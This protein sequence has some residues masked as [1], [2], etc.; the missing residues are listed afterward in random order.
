MTTLPRILIIDDDLAS[1]AERQTMICEALALRNSRDKTKTN[2]RNYLA[3]A[4]FETGQTNLSDGSKVNDLDAVMK[5]IRK[6]WPSKVDGERWA[7][8]CIDLSFNVGTPGSDNEKATF[9]GA[10][11]VGK[12]RSTWPEST[13]IVSETGT[14]LPIA[15]LSSQDTKEVSASVVGSSVPCLEKRFG[16]AKAM[17]KQFAQALFSHGLVRD[18][19]LR[20]PTSPDV[21][22]PVDRRHALVTG[23][24]FSVLRALQRARQLLLTRPYQN[25]LVVGSLGSES[26]QFAHYLNDHLDVAHRLFRDASIPGK[27]EVK[28]CLAREGAPP[29]RLTNF[30][31]VFLE[32]L[33]DL[34]QTGYPALRELA[35]NGERSYLLAASIDPADAEERRLDQLP[36]NLR[37]AFK[38]LQWPPL[39]ERGCDASTFFAEQLKNALVQCNLPTPPIDPEAASYIDKNIADFAQIRDLAEEIVPQILYRPEVLERDVRAAFERI[40]GRTNATEET[41][42]IEALEVIRRTRF[43]NGDLPQSWRSLRDALSPLILQMFST[44]A[45]QH[46]VTKD[47][48]TDG[49]T[50]WAD[51]IGAPVYDTTK[52]K[53]IPR[54][55]AYLSKAFELDDLSELANAGD[56]A[57]ESKKTPKGG[58]DA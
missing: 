2:D 19:C 29:S 55:L 58:K 31:T 26:K 39:S 34:P 13:D 28:I 9:F 7:L 56:E 12:I 8:I 10:E 23:G 51:E 38:T 25:I 43:R 35:E 11:I 47:R 50:D 3:E 44:G 17:R 54:L 46:L 14:K 53:N 32:R 49:W 41:S 27:K 36:Q 57:T 18:G 30:S 1:S 37:R 45:M 48:R 42:F 6:G 15:M 21:V 24:S 4:V 22:A 16:D 5:T 52:R 33:D 20:M 40:G